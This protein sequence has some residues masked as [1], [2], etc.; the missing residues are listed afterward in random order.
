MI[1]QSDKSNN[2][3]SKHFSSERNIDAHVYSK[4][5]QTMLTSQKS[6]FY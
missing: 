5:A 2:N 4:Q 1:Q 3:K 6:G